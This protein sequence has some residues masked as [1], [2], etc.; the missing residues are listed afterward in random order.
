MSVT[1]NHITSLTDLIP[2]NVQDQTFT[3]PSMTPIGVYD[4]EIEAFVQTFTDMDKSTR[5]V[6]IRDSFEVNVID[7][8]CFKEG[9]LI[10]TDIV[11]NVGDLPY[12][13]TPYRGK[14]T[15]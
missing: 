4:V 15:Q 9:D 2:H 5:V 8:P 1:G 11:V 14:S 3:V 10:V 6:R 13:S 7:G 12:T